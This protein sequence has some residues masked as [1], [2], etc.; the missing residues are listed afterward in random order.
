VATGCADQ[1]AF[2]HAEVEDLGLERAGR[3]GASSARGPRRVRR[4]AR[5]AMPAR[6]KRNRERCS[7]NRRRCMVLFYPRGRGAASGRAEFCVLA[8]VCLAG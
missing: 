3:R 1:P 6:R 2:F 4:H 7:H 8:F 5:G